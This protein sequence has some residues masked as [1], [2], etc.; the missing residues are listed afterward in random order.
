MHAPP[1]GSPLPVHR[2]GRP[3]RLDG[4]SRCPAFPALRF[5]IHESR[6]RIR[7]QEKQGLPPARVE[8]AFSALC[9]YLV[10][11]T[12]NF[13]MMC[14]GDAVLGNSPTRSQGSGMA[15]PPKET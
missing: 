13:P 11:A 6:P 12:G 10:C 1:D 14:M 9:F 3:A 8:P 2:R 4:K 5:R 7:L 15:E